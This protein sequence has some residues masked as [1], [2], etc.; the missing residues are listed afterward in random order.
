MIKL[1]A[2]RPGSGDQVYDG[3]T[4]VGERFAGADL[5][6]RDLRF[7][8]FTDCELIRCRFDGSDLT[9]VHVGTSTMS[10]LDVAEWKLP[11][12][13]FRQVSVERCRLGSLE[14]YESAWRSVEVAD[15]KIGYLNARAAQWQDVTFRDC[16]ITELD[17]GQARVDRMRFER[18]R[19]DELHLTGATLADVDLREA[20]LTALDG[21]AG[22]AGCTITALQLDLLAP[23]LARHLGLDV[24]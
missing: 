15:S 21:L 24:Q 14:F 8:S 9:G 17:L 23:L 6:G 3:D 20:E 2:L 7:T 5:G 18:C 4:V 10:D 13:E 11:R 16:L 19:I 22:L 1:P 12:S